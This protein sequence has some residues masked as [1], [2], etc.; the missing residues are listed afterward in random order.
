MFD[1]TT[2]IAEVRNLAAGLQEPARFEEVKRYHRALIETLNRTHTNGEQDALAML[3][4]IALVLAQQ[5]AALSRE[6][7]RGWL[8][9]VAVEVEHYAPE[10]RAAGQAAR[11]IEDPPP[12]R[13]SFS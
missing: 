4:A 2:T 12:A 6:E 9:F 7:R 5:T 8:T 10:F 13:S 1:D 11:V 3:E